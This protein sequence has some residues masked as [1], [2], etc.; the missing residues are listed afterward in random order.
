MTTAVCVD[1]VS[2]RFTIGAAERGRY[3]TLRETIVDSVRGPLGR[4]GA[5][6]RSVVS[7]RRP[8][9][10]AA[11]RPTDFWALK[12]V[13]FDIPSGQMV[14]IIGHNG[15]GKS[16]LLKVLSR[17]TQP[18]GGEIRLRGRLGSLLEV[19][20]GFHPE[21]T[22]KENIYLNGAIMGMTRREIAAK[23]DDIVAFAEVKQFINTPVKRYSSGMYVRLA[24]AVAAY[25]NPDI[26]LIDEVLSVG[27][28]AF[29][30]KCM[31]HARRLRDRNTTV[32]FVSHNMFAV[33]SMCDRAIC[34]AH[35]EVVFDGD[36][37]SAI[38]RYEQ[39]SGGLESLPWARASSQDPSRAPVRVTRLE[40]LDEAGRPRTVFD[41][42][43]RMRLRIHCHAQERIA[44]PN[45]V[46][47]FMRSD[48]TACCNYNTAMD[49]VAIPSL[50][51]SA[52]VE[53][54][55]PPLKLVSEMYMI[56]LLIWDEK[57]QKLYSAQMGNTFH[58]RHDLLDT[59]FGVFH[60]SADWH[61]RPGPGAPAAEG[62]CGHFGGARP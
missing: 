9:G 18:T 21:L 45:F 13:S 11:P 37:P 58:V 54:L 61:V 25:L 60:E 40:V 24:F 22:G 28:L 62:V 17:I 1:N 52:V 46:A 43:E 26:L 44:R 38:E 36:P 35:G 34:L 53:C 32:I 4:L 10:P 6:A 3:R 56:H 59:S 23:Y 31:E 19:G 41:H 12:G 49:G 29:Q 33:K 7:R 30:R 47:S 15:A 57:F 20:T 42:G 51:G 16:T 50:H 8:G 55:T 14:G 39:C 5:C 27:D 48:N 2:K